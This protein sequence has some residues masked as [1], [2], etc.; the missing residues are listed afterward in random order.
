M[1]IQKSLPELQELVRLYLQNLLVNLWSNLGLGNPRDEKI[2][3]KSDNVCCPSS[4]FILSFG[5]AKPYK[6]TWLSFPE[7]SRSHFLRKTYSHSLDVRFFLNPH[8]FSFLSYWF[9]LGFDKP[10]CVGQILKDLPYDAMKF[11]SFSMCS[12]N[13]G[14]V[15]PKYN[16]RSTSLWAFH[17]SSVGTFVASLFLFVA[18]ALRLWY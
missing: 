16:S 7:L 15:N 13:F 8:S 11:R 5:I 17:S 12:I 10:I 1:W 3:F 9:L 6:V 14:R 18:M 4:F 2:I